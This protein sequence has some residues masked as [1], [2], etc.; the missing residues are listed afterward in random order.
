MNNQPFRP[1][2]QPAI[3]PAGNPL[4]RPVHGQNVQVAFNL[5][6][7][8]RP[9]GQGRPVLIPI[10]PVPPRVWNLPLGQVPNIPYQQDDLIPAAPNVRVAVNQG[11]LQELQPR[12][13]GIHQRLYGNMDITA[14]GTQ[15]Q[16]R[17]LTIFNHIQSGGYDDPVA[18]ATEFVRWPKMPSQAVLVGMVNEF[19]LHDI[20]PEVGAQIPGGARGLALYRI[21][22]H[23]I[24]NPPF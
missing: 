24:N 18:T 23:L 20:H 5:P 3:R 16:K 10:G 6:A 4:V 12:F 15:N 21:C 1:P 9:P 8:I 7:P 17:L 14:N 19:G 11:H 2:I 13:Q 22:H